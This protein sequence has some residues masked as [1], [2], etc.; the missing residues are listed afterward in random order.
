MSQEGRTTCEEIDQGQLDL[1]VAEASLEKPRPNREIHAFDDDEVSGVRW[2]SNDVPIR[3]GLGD[4]YGFGS[5]FENV[6]KQIDR[7]GDVDRPI[8]V[9]V[10]VLSSR[11]PST[12]ID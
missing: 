4:G 8:P 11:W 9:D 2:P 12:N 6:G 7:I 1:F 10:A 5:T 3:F